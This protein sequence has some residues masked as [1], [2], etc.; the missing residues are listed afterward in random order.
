MFNA[1]DNCEEYYL[2]NSEY[3][4]KYE[5]TLQMYSLGSKHIF[6]GYTH[7]I[8]QIYMCNGNLSTGLL[9][10]Y[11]ASKGSTTSNCNFWFPSK[12][13]LICFARDEELDEDQV[14]FIAEW[15]MEQYKFIKPRGMD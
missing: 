14:I 12:C 15:F 5:I 7:C 13:V 2:E 4:L 1:H 11:G 9:H 6:I 10:G 3:T 8:W